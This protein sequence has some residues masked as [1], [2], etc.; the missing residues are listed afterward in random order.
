MQGVAKVLNPVL[1]MG[2]LGLQGRVSSLG[3][4]PPT[5][6]RSQVAA[7]PLE[8]I[9]S[10]LEGLD[11]AAILDFLMSLSLPT[12]DAI[13]PQYQRSLANASEKNAFLSTLD[14]PPL[15][16]MWSRIRDFFDGVTPLKTFSEPEPWFIPL[17]EMHRPKVGGCRTDLTVSRRREEDCGFKVKV[18]ALGGG[19]SKKRS[20]LQ[21]QAFW[22]EA[23]CLSVQVPITVQWEDCRKN[24]QTIQR[25]HVMDIAE[26]PVALPIGEEDDKCRSFAPETGNEIP[27]APAKTGQTKKLELKR[28]WGASWGLG[29]ELGLFKFGLRAE[30]SVEHVIQFVYALEGPCTYYYLRPNKGLVYIWNWQEG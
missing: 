1:R 6:V 4:P 10:P 30:V 27:Y 8:E 20:V 28:R 18:F 24:R 22:T 12:F 11:D 26:E 9:A 29:A 23:G 3:A 17:T 15:R 2:R 21:E 13:F 19:L 7:S 14:K 16:I 5:S 25:V